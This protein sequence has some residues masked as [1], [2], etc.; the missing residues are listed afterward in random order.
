MWLY[1]ATSDDDA[2]SIYHN[3]FIPSQSGLDGPGVYFSKNKS[4]AIGKSGAVQVR[5]LD[6]VGVL[7]CW[8]PDEYVKQ[9]GSVTHGMD[10]WKVEPG[11]VDE[12]ETPEAPVIESAADYKGSG[13]GRGSNQVRKANKKKWRGGGRR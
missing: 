8:I 5:G 9:V 11:D 2:W 4:A 3:G 10:N 6:T 7:C 1:H 12:I 13:R